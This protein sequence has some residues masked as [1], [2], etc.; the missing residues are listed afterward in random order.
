MTQLLESQDRTSQLV[1]LE[2]AIPPEFPSTRSRKKL[3]IAGAVAS[4]IAAIG[5]AIALELLS[6]GIRT[7]AQMQRELGIVPVVVI[8]K[9]KRRRRSP[10]RGLLVG[11]GLLAALGAGAWAAMRW[12]LIDRIGTLLPRR[13]AMT[14][15]E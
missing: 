8:P 7:S 13:A 2:R 4:V 14:P 1:V 11:V 12:G 9:L 5:V 6:K 3:A 15:A 10:W